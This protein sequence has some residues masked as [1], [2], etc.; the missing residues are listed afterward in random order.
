MPRP[1]RPLATLRTI[2]SFAAVAA[3]VGAV[4]AQDAPPPAV[5]RAELPLDGTWLV[6]KGDEP[7]DEDFVPVAVPDAFETALG[8]E[9]DGVA[10]YRKDVVVPTALLGGR[11]FVAFDGVMTSAVVRWNGREVGRHLGGWT[12]FRCEVSDGAE[13]GAVRRL[14]VVVDEKVGHDT[15]GFLPIVQP[16]FGGIWRPVRLL[17]L[18]PV[19][20]DE[21]AALLFGDAKNSALVVEAPL[22]SPLPAGA[23]IEASVRIGARTYARVVDAPRVELPVDGFAPW[24]PSRDDAAP[25]YD[26]RV[27]LLDADGREL[28]RVERKVG[29]RTVDSD[30]RRL[31]LNGAAFNVRGVLEWGVYPPAWTPN[32]G[33]ADFA[34]QIGEARARGFNLIK[35]C[36]WI[37]PAPLLDL[38][39]RLGMAA[40]IEYPTWHATFAPATRDALLA[41]YDAFFRHDRSHPSVIVRSLTCESG[42]TAP[43]D[44][45]RALYARAHAAIPN[46]FVED[47]S[48]WIGWNRVHDFY[49]DHP[50][51]NCDAWPGVLRGF[52]AHIGAREAMPLL[53]G[54]AIAADTWLDRGAL[55]DAGPHFRPHAFDAAAAWERDLALRY[56][57]TTVD[58]LRPDSLRYALAQRKDQIEGFRFLQPDGGY[59]VSV[60]RDF[61]LASM[62]LADAFDRWKWS[63]EDWAF[64]G[65]TALLLPPRTPRAVLGGAEVALDLYVAHHGPK[66]LPAGTAFWRAGG[67]ASGDISHAEL[68]PGSL[69]KIGALRFT[70]P[71]VAAFREIEVSAVVGP[72]GAQAANRWS[73]FATP[74]SRDDAPRDV[75]AVEEVDRLTPELVDRLTSGARVLLAATDGPGSFVA[76][77]RWTLRGSWW[78]PDGPIVRGFGREALG[79][80]LV[81]DL[82]PRGMMPLAPFR[83]A[84]HPLIGFWDTHDVPRVD[85]YAFLLETR[86]GAGRLT[87]TTVPLRGGAAADAFRA[88]LLR[89]LRS[90]AEPPTAL[91]ADVAAALRERLSLR[92]L[93]LTARTDWTFRAER[94]AV[95]APE[96]WRPIKVGAHWDGQGFADF[97][98]YGRYRL[99]FDLPA[100]WTDLPLH[101]ALDGADDAYWIEFD[102][103]PCGSGGD[104]ALKKTAFDTKASHRL[105]EKAAAGPHVLE[106][107]V[108]DW[109]G[110]GGLHRPLR[111]ATAPVTD[112]ADFVKIE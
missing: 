43:L 81:H 27:R 23:R 6:A 24:R 71:S 62:G 10:T 75:A 34:R 79:E 5:A 60:A 50:Y 99:A 61:R 59:V 108:L 11:F 64:Q 88:A 42:T 33:V 66:P 100:E 48:S 93:D 104:V 14:E 111:L 2:R 41:E 103:V 86:V 72:R 102:G 74:A 55:A 98:G 106:I 69:T 105:S 45:M 92:T 49:D 83:G 76:P 15:Q 38:C 97:D 58:A 46:A 28:D 95:E 30:G 19:A 40:W 36:L 35:F 20:F 37:P 96:P 53:L 13:A 17:R 94:A 21:G 25:L 91:P 77:S 85:E 70:A 57:R 1:R 47:D 12:P 32:R 63:A 7:R 39:D 8:A 89:R 84:A 18:P 82:H 90:A 78:A 67:Q 73:F 51:G 65:D 112:R 54:E 31:L 68:A 22:D 101:L 87:A 107:R 109:Q 80:L 56:G 4:R 9:F 3:L 110:A 29:F 16:H 52:D 26:A 44:A